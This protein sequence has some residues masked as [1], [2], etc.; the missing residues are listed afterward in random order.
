VFTWQAPAG[1]WTALSDLFA[2]KKPVQ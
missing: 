1:L 2:G